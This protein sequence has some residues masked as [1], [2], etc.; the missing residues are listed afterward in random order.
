MKNKIRNINKDLIKRKMFL[1]VEIKKMIL[2]SIFQ[3]SNVKPII[4]AKILRKLGLFRKNESISRQNNNI[5][6]LT[7]RNKGVLRL[8]NLSRHM[9]KKLSTTGDVQNFKIKSW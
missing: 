9:I 5:C 3:N 4:R 2:K 1:R 6:L 7:G 8:N